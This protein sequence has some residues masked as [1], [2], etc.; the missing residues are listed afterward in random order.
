M[1]VIIAHVVIPLLTA[2]A[3]PLREGVR[4]S[5]SNALPLY[6]LPRSLED[7]KVHEV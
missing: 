1:D 3:F 5:Y 6:I 4:K 2:F 7:T